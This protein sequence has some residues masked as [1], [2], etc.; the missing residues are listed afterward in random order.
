LF[1]ANG[2]LFPARQRPYP[3]AHRTTRILA[4]RGSSCPDNNIFKD[5]PAREDGFFGR[6]DSLKGFLERKDDAKGLRPLILVFGVLSFFVFLTSFAVFYTTEN[7]SSACGCQLPIW[8]IIV[9]ISSLGLFVG[10]ITYYVLSTSFLKEKSK[11]GK[12]LVAFLEVLEGDDK[13]I[14]KSLIEN[15]GE[16][17]QSALSDS[18]GFD[19]VRTSRIISKME[20]KGIIRKER[21]GMT[22]RII[23]SDRLKD[24]FLDR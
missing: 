12:D 17:G 24:L 8:V 22:N 10:L 13:A 16:T 6:G 15:R 2:I 18:L 5:K 3:K 14:L 19:K 23:L 7:F 21:K 20:G 11:M 4:G 9:S 1:E